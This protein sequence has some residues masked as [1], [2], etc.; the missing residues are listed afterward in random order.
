MS[1]L[2][3]TI[4]ELF[5]L[6]GNKFF[7][8]IKGLTVAPGNT[9]RTF[10][11]GDR[12]A[13]LHPF[14]YVIT[15]LGISIFLSSYV[16]VEFDYSKKQNIELENEI[17]ILSQKEDL[18]KRQNSQLVLDKAF[19]NWMDFTRLNRKILFYFFFFVVSLCHLLIYRNVKFGLKKNAWFIFY[20]YGHYNLFSIPILVMTYYL[21]ILG[22]II[23]SSLLFVYLVWSSF[24]YYQISL[25]RSIKK[26]TL[27][28]LLSFAFYLFFLILSIIGYFIYVISTL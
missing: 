1:E 12:N 8:T 4:N 13:F 2:K 24:Q 10:S 7:R 15:I 18:S 5:N 26:T 14:T 20:V 23:S 25:W 3:E 21:P 28:T 6:E 17:Q 27:N 9:I 22:T 19:K 11:E 16:L